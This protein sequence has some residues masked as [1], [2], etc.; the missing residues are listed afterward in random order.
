MPG[1]GAGHVPAQ[2][3][4]GTLG[5]CR[6]P[7]VEEGPAASWEIQVGEGPSLCGHLAGSC[8][9]VARWTRAL[10]LGTSTSG[11]PSPAHSLVQQIFICTCSCLGSP[12]RRPG[13]QMG[14]GSGHQPR[15]GR[16]GSAG[17]IGVHPRPPEQPPPS[18]EPQP[19]PAGRHC[20]KSRPP[21]ADGLSALSRAQWGRGLSLYS[22]EGPEALATRVGDT[23]LCGRRSGLHPPVGC[24]KERFGA[25]EEGPAA[26]HPPRVPRPM[27]AWWASGAPPVPAQ[28]TPFPRP[29]PALVTPP[30]PGRGLPGRRTPSSVA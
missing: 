10:Q 1:P 5:A 21:S 22:G 8:W 17:G 3:A 7:A 11:C 18:P 19:C 28:P 2:D 20:W 23:E 15:S 14:P 24:H 12:L 30:P 6:W 16:Q 29:L 4:Q 26:R 25:S 27:E 9:E 13:G